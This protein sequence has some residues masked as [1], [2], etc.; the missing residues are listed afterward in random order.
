MSH[1]CIF[2]E[3]LHKRQL[4]IFRKDKEEAKWKVP[5]RENLCTQ[6]GHLTTQDKMLPPKH[7]KQ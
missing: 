7:Y 2:G 5:G 1:A 3:M 4:R 6:Q